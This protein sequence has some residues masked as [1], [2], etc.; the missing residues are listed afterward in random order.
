V[1]LPWSET[2]VSIQGEGPRA[3]RRCGFI[4]LG[5]CN[6]SC[7]WCDTPYTWDSRRYDLRREL[8]PQTVEQLI[9]NLPVCDEVV[10]TGGEPL[11]H[12]ESPG[13]AGLLRA[14]SMRSIFIAVETN[15]TISPN[16]VSQTFIGHYSISPKLA[17]AGVHRGNQNPTLAEWPNTVKYHSACLKIVVNDA[18][19][20]QQAA[21][22]ADAHGW[23]RWQ[24]WVM[25]QGTSTPALLA[26]FHDICVAA[27]EH[28]VNVS[29]RLHVLAF[30]N[31][32]GT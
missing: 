16:K 31:T 17:N 18:D 10:L 32:K 26:D 1:T 22:L 21:E 12:Q 11:I 24:T 4:R 8:K 28:G 19:E 2:F 14:L 23:P 20:V 9:A 3:G 30:G 15:G 6:L 5:G 13:W 25:P 27:I 7:S 29:Q